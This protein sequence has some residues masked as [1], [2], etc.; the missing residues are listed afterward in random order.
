[1]KYSLILLLLTL[2][3]NGCLKKEIIN[4]NNELL[5]EDSLQFEINKTTKNEIHQ[6]LGSPTAVEEIDGD[7]W[8]YIVR[9][10]DKIGFLKAKTVKQYGFLFEFDNNILTYYQ[11]IDLNNYKNISFSYEETPSFG[12][13]PSFVKEIFSN[14]GRFNIRKK[15][16]L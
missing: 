3:L 12:D 11:K 6:E 14:F 10:M 5:I 4:G 8:L 13:D 9:K 16:G 7:K 1:M 15:K 2:N